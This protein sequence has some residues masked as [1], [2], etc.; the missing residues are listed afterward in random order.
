MVI[1]IPEIII[2]IIL[3]IELIYFSWIYYMDNYK[4]KYK[5]YKNK[6]VELSDSAVHLVKEKLIIVIINFYS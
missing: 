1:D 2:L 5:K 4:Y 3:N 6:Y